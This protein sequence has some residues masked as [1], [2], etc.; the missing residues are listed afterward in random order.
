[1]GR[2]IN[3]MVTGMLIGVSVGVMVLPQL[4]RKTQKTVRRFSKKMVNRAMGS[5]DGIVGILD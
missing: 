1:M 2:C 4:D 5:Y 3:G